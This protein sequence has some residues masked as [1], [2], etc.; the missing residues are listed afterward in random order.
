MTHL[1]PEIR[2]SS[3]E[4]LEWIV[5]DDDLGPAAVSAAAGWGKT[6]SVFGGLLGWKADS[7]DD[8]ESQSNGTGKGWSA[9]KASFGKASSAGDGRV[10]IRLLAV[11]AAFLRAG[12]AGDHSKQAGSHPTAFP[13]WNLESH[14][15]PNISRPFAPLNLFGAVRDDE[16]AMYEDRTERQRFFSERWQNPICKGAGMAKKEG[17]EIG[18]AAGLVLR[19]IEVGMEDFE[20]G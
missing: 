5:E 13:V 16:G 3:L 2:L 4:V 15:I 19:A 7:P 6:L 12:L 18:R 11:L 10:R 8:Q 1:A 14:M 17:G 20:S 9:P